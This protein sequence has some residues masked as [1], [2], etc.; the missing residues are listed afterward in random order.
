MTMTAVKGV[1]KSQTFG[2]FL[3]AAL[4]VEVW[5]ATGWVGQT[6]AGQRWRSALF[7]RGQAGKLRV[8]DKFPSLNLRYLGGKERKMEVGAKG[9]WL[10]WARD[11]TSCS[12]PLLGSVQSLCKEAHGLPCYVILRS[13]SQP[14]P[15]LSHLSFFLDEDG[16]AY[17]AADVQFTPRLY[18][19]G[20]DRRLRYIQR[21]DESLSAALESARRWAQA[22]RR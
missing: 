19:V 15:S 11:C 1:L 20:P 18:V 17:E 6:E 14:P 10:L 21:I 8:G 12:E 9:A 4:C 3:F 2:V 7:R 5:I 22:N 16:S 13:A